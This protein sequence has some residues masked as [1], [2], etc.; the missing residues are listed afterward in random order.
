MLGA[1]ELFGYAACVTSEHKPRLSAIERGDVVDGFRHLT[2]LRLNGE[3]LR[4]CDSGLPLDAERNAN[5]AE[6]EPV[7]ASDFA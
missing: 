7:D 1:M 6:A 4:D 3:K 5:A 2:L